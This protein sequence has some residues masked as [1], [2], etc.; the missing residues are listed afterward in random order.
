MAFAGHIHEEEFDTRVGIQHFFEA[1]IDFIM[2]SL[3]IGAAVVFIATCISLLKN[4]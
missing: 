2:L 4:I 3:A 1:T